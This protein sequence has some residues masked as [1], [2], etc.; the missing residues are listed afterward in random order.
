MAAAAAVVVEREAILTSL[1]ALPAAG[2]AASDA[3]LLADAEAWEAIGRL[4]DGRRAAVAAEVAWRSR[5]QLAAAGLAFGQGQRNGVDLLTRNLRIS[6]RE[7]SR[8]IAIGGPVTPRSSLTGEELPG[9]FPTV[10]AAVQQ[11]EIALD[12]ARIIT[13]TLTAVRRRASVEELDLAEAA[14]TDAASNTE[15]DLLRIHASVWAMRLDP[16]GAKPAEEEQRRQRSLRIGRTDEHGI[17]TVI[18]KLTAEDLA[19]LKAG[20]QAHRRGVAFTRDGADEEDLDPEWHEAD[21]DQRTPMQLDY[22]TFMSILRAGLRAEEEGSGGSLKTPHEVIAHIDAHDLET[23]QGQGYLDG[24]L[25]RVSIPTVERTTCSGG[26]R[27][28]VHGPGGEPLWLGHP[29]RLFTAAQKKAIA[30]R[31]GGCAWPGCTAPVCWCEA[32]HI[33]WHGRDHGRTDVD[34]GVLLCSFHHHRI[35]STKEWEIRLHR[36]VPHLVPTGW[37][38]PPLPRHRMQQHRKHDVKRPQPPT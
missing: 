20:L 9:R 2:R 21:G 18:E 30:A 8:R 22:D 38:G 6:S 26:V 23:R 24:V 16:D 13:D 10:A 25:A 17:T 28:F 1:R 33:Q 29:V 27:Y 36:R 7:A 5:P 15:P 14:L 12:A 11:G 35:H 32:H 4:I 34:N 3:E 37:Q 19:V 31:D